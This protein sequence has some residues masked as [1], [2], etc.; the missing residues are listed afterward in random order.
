[1]KGRT[2][3]AW[4]LRKLRTERGL[5]QEKLAADAAVDRAYLGGM[6][7]EQENPSIDALDKVAAALGIGL[8]ELFVAPAEG[9]KP[10]AP[11]RP[12]RR[13]NKGS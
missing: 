4:N 10:P 9:D 2:I 8:A 1:M 12:G 7:R 11:L 5:S 13:A 3:L 6:E